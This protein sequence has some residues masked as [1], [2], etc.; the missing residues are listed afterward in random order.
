M[1]EAPAE[2][3]RPTDQPRRL[4][5]LATPGAIDWRLLTVS[6]VAWPLSY[7]PSFAQVTSEQVV[8]SASAWV[9]AF[10]F[11]HIVYSLI[12][13][14]GKYTWWRL[15]FAVRHPSILAVSIFIATLV[16]SGFFHAALQIFGGPANIAVEFLL[17]RF[18]LL[19]VIFVLAARFHLFREKLRDLEATETSLRSLFQIAN[20]K[21]EAEL[22]ELD[23]RLGAVIEEAAG[24]KGRQA[25]EAADTLQRL[26]DG[27]VRPWSHELATADD[28]FLAPREFRPR[29]EW[30]KVWGAI[31]QSSLLRP[32]AM[33][34]WASVFA[35]NY[36][37]QVRTAHTRQLPTTQTDHGLEVTVEG[38]SLMR[39][40]V[41][42]TS[43]FLVVFLVSIAVRA[44]MRAS[45]LPL[46]TVSGAKRE[47]VGLGLMTML[48]TLS[49]FALLLVTEGRE[50]LRN[51][52]APALLLALA[53]VMVALAAALFRAAAAA[54]TSIL[55][56]LDEAYSALRWEVI[57]ANQSL[58]KFRQDAANWLHGPIR[59]ALIATALTLKRAEPEGQQRL[60][61]LIERL[62]LLQTQI[63]SGF[64]TNNPLDIA[65]ETAELWRGSCEVSLNFDVETIDSLSSDP[66]CA[67]IVGLIINESV[68]NAITHGGATEVRVELILGESAVELMVVD[69]GELKVG[70]NSGLGSK[71][72]S[73]SA[74]HWQR[75]ARSGKTTLEVVL[76]FVR[77]SA[78]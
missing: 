51:S 76:P 35:I 19:L 17:L 29:P 70:Q 16:A 11:G 2:P 1:A 15:S 55:E 38:E 71:F 42:L 73:E 64:G 41:A 57:R 5:A 60:S 45:W 59:S 61:D 50:S 34:V 36:S 8:R 33:A 25:A 63:G 26:S 27:V 46:R 3:E 53:I 12:L 62:R 31:F 18:V 68:V 4:Q 44:L 30:R 52:V 69:N 77:G 14:L 13:I 21:R 58:W 7:A 23:R 66:T 74:L 9:L 10:A 6:S 40:V 22:V 54:S 20:L 24:S 75:E 56:Q 39:F 43:V 65:L 48:S 49:L 37:V 67:S 47:L 32:T 78:H 72:M 28:V